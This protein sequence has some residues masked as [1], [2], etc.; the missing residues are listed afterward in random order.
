MSASISS[1]VSQLGSTLSQTPTTPTSTPA[2]SNQE[3]T[4]SENKI[5]FEELL[6]SSNEEIQKDRAT[7]S[8]N[9]GSVFTG[10]ESQ[11][12]FLSK[13]SEYGKPKRQDPKNV[14]NK[15]DFLKLFITQLS[16]QDPLKPEDSAEMSARL[17]QFNSLE[18][19]MNMNT[20]LDKLIQ[21]QSSNTSKDLINYIG[22][23]VKLSQGWMSVDDSTG[24][25]APEHIRFSLPQDASSC[26][27][28]IT[29]ESG[30]VIVSKSLGSC[31]KGAHSFD[32]DG[33]LENNQKAPNGKY[34][35][36]IKASDI[37]GAGIQADMST[38]VKITGVDIK[39]SSSPLITD[40]G[41]IKLEDI[42]SIE[43]TSSKKETQAR[44]TTPTPT[45]NSTPSPI[46][47][48]K[49]PDSTNIS[50]NSSS[51]GSFQS[52]TKVAG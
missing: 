48:N 34:L 33:L 51:P 16:N 49:Q 35:Y 5:N 4:Q 37:N 17:A 28:D 29:D 41:K 18:Q 14:L 22:K 9:K 43:D 44:S 7:S 11:E 31:A 15:D 1:T 47:S 38:T 39:D 45:P 40:I 25:S 2:S 36:S 8:K 3:G 30:N 6:K 46:R 32:W 10:E 20:S 12:E 19:M 21:M 42:S 24:A 26:S 50:Q 27:V 52:E 23:E 13:L